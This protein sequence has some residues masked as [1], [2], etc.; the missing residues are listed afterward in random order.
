MPD[1]ATA[2]L[3]LVVAAAGAAGVLTANLLTSRLAKLQ[4]RRALVAEA[5][6]R[7]EEHRER[8][9]REL[10]AFDADFGDVEIEFG[11]LKF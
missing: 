10:A 6:R 2:Q 8:V 1:P 4:R 7:R 9:Q 11:P 5:V 3:L